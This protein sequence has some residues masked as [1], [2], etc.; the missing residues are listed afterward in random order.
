MKITARMLRLKGACSPQ[1]ELFRSVFPR[2]AR[3]TLDNLKKAREAGLDVGWIVR[4]Q[5]EEKRAAYKAATAPAYA[6]YE[7]ATAQAWAAYQAAKAPALAAYQAATAPALAAY[8]AA[9][10]PAWAAYQ[11]ATAQ[12][13]AAY[14]A[15]TDSA[16]ISAFAEE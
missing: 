5:P 4:Q 11:A 9:K 2:G 10:A 15:A 13:L 8:Q 16:F 3:V 14:Q 7:A 12:A 6:A 1:V